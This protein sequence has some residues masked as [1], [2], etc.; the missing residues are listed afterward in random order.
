MDGAARALLATDP[1]IVVAQEV[2]VYAVQS[3]RPEMPVVFGF[4]GDPV[5]GGL[6]DSI[7]RPGRAFT[8]MSYLALGLVGK[9]I[10][11]LKEWLPALERVA[12]LAQPQHPGAL[13]ERRVT[14]EA[15]AALGVTLSYYPIAGE[16]GIDDALAAVRRDGC[17]ALVVFSDAT[18]YGA[19]GRIARFAIA[20]GLP[21]VSGWAPFAAS[22]FL[23]TYGANIRELYRSLARYVDQILRGA[24]AAELPVETPSTIEMVI[25]AATA[26]ALG[27]AIPP[28]TL[29][30]RADVVI[31]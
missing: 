11:L 24:K 25:N 17:D 4:S 7:A 16:A 15:A 9:R 14:D 31:E 20:A 13:L 26:S 30:A 6:V 5:A 28:P 23:L 27:L 8:G 19:S 12:V 1:E 2:M 21:T 10:E 3:L 22:G 29:L 18:M